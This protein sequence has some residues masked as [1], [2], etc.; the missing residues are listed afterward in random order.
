[1]ISNKYFESLDGT[2]KTFLADFVIKSE[3]YC[4]VYNYKYDPSGVDGSVDPT[5]G[6]FVRTNNAPTSDDQLNL[7]D[8]ALI[9]NIVAFYTAPPANTT[10]VIEVATT[11][12]ELGEAVAGSAVLQAQDA[13]DLAE[14][15]RDEAE[16]LRDTVVDKE[17]LMNP[18]YDAIDAVYANET[19]INAVN[20]N[21]A[22][23]NTVAGIDTDVTTVAGIAANVTTVA[24]NN[25]DV[26][27]V[28]TDITNVNTVATNI[29]NVNSAVANEANINSVVANATNINTVATDIDNVNAVSTNIANVISVDGNSTNINSAVANETN[30]NTVATDITNVNTVS[31]N[32]AD[33]NSVAAN[34]TNI[35]TVATDIANVNTTAA[36]IANVNTVSTNI[37]D[38]TTVADNIDNVNAVGTDI[39]N[40]NT[41]AT[42]LTDINYFGNNYKIAATEPSS[43]VEGMLWWDTTNDTMKV[44]DGASFVL[45]GS[46]PVD[47]NEVTAP[48]RHSIRPS[49]LLDF[50]NSKTLDPRITYS[51]ASTA[52]H[53][54]EK[55]R[56][57]TVASGEPRFDHDPVTGESKGLL[58]E[59]QRT[60]LLTYSE[61]T[62]GVARATE[63]VDAAISPD[64]TQNAIWIQESTDTGSHYALTN[65]VAISSGTD[66]TMSVYL[67][68]A[69]R[70]CQVWNANS[71]PWGGTPYGATFDLS[72]GTVIRTLN[73]STATITDVG[74]G[75]YR[76][77]YTPATTTASG[78]SGIQLSFYDGSTTNYTGDGYSGIYAWGFQIEAGSFPTSYIPTSGSQ[79]TRSADNAS[80]TGTNFSD[81]YRQDEGTLYF[82]FNQYSTNSTAVLGGTSDGSFNNTI[83]F[84]S[85]SATS[86]GTFVRYNNVSQTSI[87]SNSYDKGSNS[88]VG[89]AYALDDLAFLLDGLTPSTDSS[90]SIPSQDRLVIGSSPW[91]ANT[92]ALGGTIKKLAYYPKR[93]T[94]AE[95]Q[96]L[97]ED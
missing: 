8:W 85:P 62:N 27:T 44:Y 83:Y 13:R 42:S 1:M 37:A 7:D 16:A 59:E 80:M 75:W 52:T 65:G 33:V 72:N 39:A 66:Y 23:I 88:K 3:Q 14:Q 60:N 4:R 45:A 19:N 82:D 68:S 28:A 69:G 31:T 48:T 55:G 84:N 49:L 30:I 43:P 92:N 56:L 26:T 36:S 38:V 79:V 32:I 2:T 21:E 78:S 74:N 35:N 41:A 70:S 18:H 10:L 77:S 15:Y 63:T 24:T 54:D 93:L 89:F 46:Q 12:E 25:T 73:G 87:G 64:G 11:P 6:L 71:T 47:V 96:A 51:R 97:T 40:V 61:V 81:W 91:A 94:N 22:N 5:S 53:Y 67:K 17:A 58:I 90:A 29:A 9:N 50:A 20:D 57:V 86:I 76:C 34:E 95:L